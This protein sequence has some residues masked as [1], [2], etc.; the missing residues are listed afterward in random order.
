MWLVAGLGNPGA[1][2]TK[3]RHN[4]GFLVLDMLSETHAMPFRETRDCAITKG[5]LQGVEVVLVEP[6]TFM[7]RSGSAVKKIAD[8]YCICPENLIVVHDDL[9][10]DTGRL[11]IRR[12]GSS[13]GHKGVDSIMQSIGSDSFIR[14]KIGIGREHFMPVE[15]Y[16]LSRFSKDDLPVIREAVK[17]AADAVLCVVTEGVEKAMNRYNRA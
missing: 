4:V 7:N 12:S 5:N 11:K 6:L 8:K 3:T 1:K 13:G 16:V 2:Y 10:L 9:D 17:R 14:I 15:E